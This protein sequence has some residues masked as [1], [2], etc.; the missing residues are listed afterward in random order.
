M[1]DIH[2]KGQYFT[3]NVYLKETVSSLIGNNP[4][5]ILEPSVGQGDL[6]DYIKQTNHMIE[7]DMYE[8]DPTITLLNSIDKSKLIYGDF[9]SIK[10]DATYKTIIGNPPYVKTTNGNLYLEFIYKCYTLLEENGELIFIV[11]SD[12]LKLT[13]SVNILNE[14]LSEGTFTHIIHPNK[15]NLFDNAS[16]DIIIFR[17]CKNPSLSNKILF[18]DKEKFLINTKGTITFSDTDM[19]TDNK[20]CPIS[21]YF[22]CYVGMVTGKEAIFKNSEFGNIQLL[23]NKDKRDDYI[24]INKFPTANEKL[25]QYLLNNKTALIN[26]KIRKF[27]DHNWF[28][29]G[30]LRNYKSITNELGKDC[31]YISNLT[32]NSEVAFIDKVSYFGGGLL[33]LI[34]KGDIELGKVVD[35]LNSRDFKKN[36]TYS[37]RFKIGHRQLCNSLGNFTEML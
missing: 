2:Q 23:N 26:R 25:N 33:M 22:N 6:V 24:L 34:P 35:Y 27:N 15:E 21:D 5:K 29:W 18:N 32:R 12:F 11:P 31:I 7:F 9:L 16:I 19:D 13:S 28:E 30:A 17:Y 10:I 37:G 8:I 20:M 1:K 36:Y 3:T 14:M 4:D